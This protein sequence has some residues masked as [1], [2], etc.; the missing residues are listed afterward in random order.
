M[1]CKLYII[2]KTEHIPDLF[3]CKLYTASESHIMFIEYS[4]TTLPYCLLFFLYTIC[5]GTG[6]ASIL[7]YM[8]V[9]TMKAFYSILAKDLWESGGICCNSPFVSFR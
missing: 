3:F 5:T 7:L 9:V 6:V 8:C 2:H 4:C 1:F